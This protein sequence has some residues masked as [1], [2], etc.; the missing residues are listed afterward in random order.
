LERIAKAHQYGN[1]LTP[2]RVP[3]PQPFDKQV[4]EQERM[5]I[6]DIRSSFGALDHDPQ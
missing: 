3:P 1:K 2:H 4:G 5:Q 6:E